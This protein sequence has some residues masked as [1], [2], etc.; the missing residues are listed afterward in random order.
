MFDV[1]S[2]ILMGAAT[3]I[4]VF[5][6]FWILWTTLKFGIAGMHWILF[7]KDT[8]PPGTDAF[9]LRNAFVGSLILLGLSLL[10]GVPVGL[11]ARHMAGGIRLSQ[12]HRQCCSFHQR[13]HAQRAIDRNWLVRI[14]HHCRSDG[15]LFGARRQCGAGDS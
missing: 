9:G 2:K 8:P 12:P 11:M 15:A 6:L 14:C 5:F 13:Y 3:V 10:I 4:G 1:T 7:T